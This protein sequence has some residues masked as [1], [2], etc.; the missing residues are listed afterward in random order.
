M[1]YYDED[2]LRD[3]HKYVQEYVSENFNQDNK[4]DKDELDSVFESFVRDHTAKDYILNKAR[5]IVPDA[6][7]Y[8]IWRDSEG[9]EHAVHPDFYECS[10]TPIDG[11]SGE[12][13][14]YIRT[15][16]EE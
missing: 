8:H 5:K 12:D 16:I 10:G 9:E 11:E 4:P 1:A 13:M 15:E 3:F 14:E 6:K 7:I 2:D